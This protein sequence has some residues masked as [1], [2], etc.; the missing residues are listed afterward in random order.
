MCLLLELVVPHAHV[1]G[2]QLGL[3][4]FCNASAIA[5]QALAWLV[6]HLLQQLAADAAG[7][8]LKRSARRG[9]GFLSGSAARVRS[10]VCGTPLRLAARFGIGVAP[11]RFRRLLE[12]LAKSGGQRVLFLFL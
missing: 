9:G 8:C 7:V 2:A 6:S 1:F 3:D 10:A 4:C 11:S 12:A 5:S